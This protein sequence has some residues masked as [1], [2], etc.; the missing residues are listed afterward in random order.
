MQDPVPTKS[1]W[2]RRWLSLGML[3]VLALLAFCH[4]RVTV[5]W[6]GLS[7][8]FMVNHG[9]LQTHLGRHADFSVALTDLFPSY[10][11]L[12]RPALGDAPRR[13][14]EEDA[15]G[16]THGVSIPIWLLAGAVLLW[17]GCIEIYTKRQAL[18]PEPKNDGA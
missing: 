18:K 4:L 9:N 10:F 3:G 13:E 11:E 2:R 12:A 15:Y 14:G 7:G 17:V 8:F 16:V 5:D 6:K 1:F